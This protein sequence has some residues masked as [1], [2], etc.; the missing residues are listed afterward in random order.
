[1]DPIY[2]L[3]VHLS[4]KQLPDFYKALGQVNDAEVD[5]KKKWKQTLFTW[6]KDNTTYA[7]GNRFRQETET[8]I[9]CYRGESIWERISSRRDSEDQPR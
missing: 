8:W 4:D 3:V 7:Q 5:E 9:A 1:M 2:V 6:V